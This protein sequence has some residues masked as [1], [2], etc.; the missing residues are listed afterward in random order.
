MKY[1]T[2]WVEKHINFKKDEEFMIFVVWAVVAA[3]LFL[4]VIN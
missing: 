2:K 1:L 3:S 4:S